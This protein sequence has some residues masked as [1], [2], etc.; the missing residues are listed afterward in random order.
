M[1]HATAVIMSYPAWSFSI[2]RSLALAAYVF[3]ALAAYIYIYIYTNMHKVRP[4]HILNIC[5]TYA[6]QL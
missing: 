6:I 4:N 2:L 1:K 5:L 3:L